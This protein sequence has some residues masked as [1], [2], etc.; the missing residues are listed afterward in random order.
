LNETLNIARLKRELLEEAAEDYVGL[1]AAL[2]PL[3]EEL[4][5]EDEA[6][7]RKIALRVLSDLLEADLI[8]AGVPKG[9]VRFDAWD[10]PAEKVLE[11]IERE[12][13]EL[14]R[15]PDIGE[16]VWFDITERGERHVRDYSPSDSSLKV[17]QAE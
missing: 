16:V 14:G 4:G 13:D 3:R 8:R 10:L 9:R 17:E 11:R 1:W 5:I 15:E 6:V 12:W 2:W 7:R